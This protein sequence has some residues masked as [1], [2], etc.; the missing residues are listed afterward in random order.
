MD[1][2]AF[3]QV[4]LMRTSCSRN[5][6]PHN[7][8]TWQQSCSISGTHR[9]LPALCKGNCGQDILAFETSDCNQ[10][11]ASRSQWATSSTLSYLIACS[12]FRVQPILLNVTIAAKGKVAWFVAF[13]HDHFLLMVCSLSWT[14]VCPAQKCRPIRI[15]SAFVCNT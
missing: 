6:V 4:L 3:A 14:Q 9:S 12:L 7:A 8:D 10:R 15:L 13:L 2:C 11:V 5:H 1:Y